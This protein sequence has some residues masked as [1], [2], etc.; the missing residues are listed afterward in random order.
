MDKREQ[1]E[2][3]FQASLMS[4]LREESYH[5]K[6]ALSAEDASITSNAGYTI[7][8]PTYD[9][10]VSY[11]S[12]LMRRELTNLTS[13]PPTLEIRLETRKQQGIGS[14]LIDEASGLCQIFPIKNRE[15][16]SIEVPFIIVKGELV[17]FDVIQVGNERCPYSKENLG[18]IMM[19]MSQA[20]HGGMLGTGDGMVALE[21]VTNPTTTSGFLSDTLNVRARGNVIPDIGG[22]YVTAEEKKIGS[23]LKEAATLKPYDWS[24]TEKVAKALCDK[25]HLELIK[26]ASDIGEEMSVM[27]KTASNKSNQVRAL[28]WVKLYDM[29]H[30]TYVK[31]P[32]MNGRDIAMTAGRILCD[33][34]D[35][36][37]ATL[38]SRMRP[39]AD[40]DK[41]EETRQR[42]NLGFNARH[43]NK[44][45][46]ITADGRMRILTPDSNVI[47][48]KSNKKL[49]KHTGCQVED[50]K[51]GDVFII[52]TD[53]GKI[54]PPKR[55][56]EVEVRGAVPF[57]DKTLSNLTMCD[58][59]SGAWRKDKTK[60]ETD[61][62][63][64]IIKNKGMHTITV[65][66]TKDAVDSDDANT[67]WY[68]STGT[69]CES[70]MSYLLMHKNVPLYDIVPMTEFLNNE[71][72]YQ[73][74]APGDLMSVI[75]YSTKSRVPALTPSKKVVKITGT[76]GK[77]FSSVD[78]M[79]RI[80]YGS[81]DNNFGIMVKTASQ[82]ETIDIQKRGDDKF[83]VT[84][85]YTDR[86]DRMYTSRE[87]KMS[88]L[89]ESAAIG[90]L[91][92][93]KFD[94]T[95]AT[96]IMLKATRNGGVSCHLP[97]GSD[98]NKIFG[99]KKRQQAID[100]T[101]SKLKNSGVEN[102]IARFVK[103]KAIGSIAKT[104]GSAISPTIAAGVEGSELAF[105]PAFVNL[106]MD[107][108]ASEN[109]SPAFVGEV[110][111]DMSSAAEEAQSL[112]VAIEK[113]AEENKNGGMRKVA[114]TMALCAHFNQDAAKV[115]LSPEDYPHFIKLAE[116][117]VSNKEIFE[118][119]VGDLIM[120]KTAGYYNDDHKMPVT[121]YGRAVYH[122]D[123]M[124]NLATEVAASVGE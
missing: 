24:E 109:Y 16:L 12:D 54:T 55:V 70:Y 99:S 66:R 105:S 17:P 76:V 48:L 95:S 21:K 8:N 91:I 75:P 7:P 88:G 6:L 9:K 56:T 117:I 94:K 26:E 58:V 124:F 25:K 45:T 72:A 121:Y 52:K 32:E 101:I 47:G 44:K 65:I 90:A 111:K 74:C 10:V 79:E 57:S 86:D 38:A 28:S 106:V 5:E 96:D 120:E 67:L 103:R 61:S 15:E 114:K 3:L 84:L 87:E 62:N 77:T 49:F 118:N 92:A 97:Q 113:L 42:H 29:P 33:Y 100:N 41:R 81:E 20:A 1:I 80:M 34:D 116:E 108:G 53:K 50:L 112:S 60:V 122:L 83:D 19:G 4:G 89:S 23:M 64:R 35:E 27:I 93:L 14:K 51:R 82:N 46:L 104:L 30:G 36:A 18:K 22:M 107:K 119:I 2:Q 69:H 59:D 37:E 115:Y 63:S 11:V 73:A 68:N 102:S 85:R 13:E 40:E 39:D 123:R 31:F 43:G 110:T 78:E 98:P 71:A